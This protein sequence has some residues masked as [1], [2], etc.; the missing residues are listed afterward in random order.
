MRERWQLRRTSANI[1]VTRGILTG[2][3]EEEE[4]PRQRDRRPEDP[5][6][7]TN[8]QRKALCVQEPERRFVWPNQYR[9]ALTRSCRT[10]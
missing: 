8:K 5:K 4:L 3:E 10:L 1:Q 6:A 2:E 7:K 9:E